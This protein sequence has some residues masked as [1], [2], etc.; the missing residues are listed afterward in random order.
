LTHQEAEKERKSNFALQMTRCPVNYFL[1]AADL[2]WGVFT[3][4][5]YKASNVTQLYALRFFVGALGGFFFPAV[6]WYLGS[7]YKRSELSRRGAIFFIASQVGSMS[8]G[9]IQAGAYARLDGRY[10][11]EG[12]RWLYIICEIRF[13][14]CSIHVWPC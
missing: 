9:Y 2:L 5:Q 3:L 10:G 4:A 11:I 1:P 13:E 14:L 7:W 12:W 6:Q 8:S